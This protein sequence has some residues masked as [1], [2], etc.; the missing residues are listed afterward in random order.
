[1]EGVYTMAELCRA[2]GVSR[3][4][5]Y[6]WVERYQRGSWEALQSE[7][8][9]PEHHWNETPESVREAVLAM[10][11][12]Y[13]HW[14][15]PKIKE[16]LRQADEKVRWPAESTIGEILRREG[17]TVPRR[18]RRRTPPYEQALVRGEHPNG[19]W[20]ADFKGWFR[21]R[22][23]ERCDPLTISD[24]ES[25]YLLRCQLVKD[26][27]TGSV[28]SQFEAT[29]REYGLPEAIRTD[30][31][32]PFASRGIGGLSQLSVWWIR[33]G[34]R[35]ERIEPGQPQQ[36]GQH[37]RI[38]RTMKAEGTQRPEST[39][40]R[41]QAVLDEFRQR[42]NEERPHEALDMRC[43]AQ[44]YERS[45]REYPA[46]VPPV[47]YPARWTVR[48]VQG[49]GVFFWKGGQVFLGE[50]L[51]Y[52]PVGFEAVDDRRW[53]VYYRT[54]LLGEFNEAEHSIIPVDGLR[55]PAKPASG[56]PAP[57]RYAEGDRE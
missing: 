26:T 33:L 54:V 22:D 4:T 34:I 31:G 10:R 7:S 56:L 37:E 13:P 24:L 16:K 19:V 18:R 9:A 27:G 57:F 53:N 30:N 21:T 45:G 14:G 39:R 55:L 28:R 11:R 38:H 47:D 25:R 29:F 36:N 5:G 12:R 44:V 49:N 35:P 43:P 1:M 32:A 50:A 40:P 48:Q 3:P 41:Q 51:Q 15:A 46:R 20:C 23:G 6:K 52:E 8:R 42:Y 2:Y 17:L